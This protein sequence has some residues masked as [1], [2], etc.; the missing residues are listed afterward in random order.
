LQT[1]VISTRCRRT[2]TE[3]KQ[4][5]ESGKARRKRSG[6]AVEKVMRSGGC[7]EGVVE[8]AKEGG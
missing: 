4:E 5:R 2:A 3:E 8:S 6:G 7:R 1:S